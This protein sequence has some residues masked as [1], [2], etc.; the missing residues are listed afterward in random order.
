MKTIKTIMFKTTSLIYVYIMFYI[1]YAFLCVQFSNYLGKSIDIASENMD[2][3]V[4]YSFLMIFITIGMFVSFI[5]YRFVKNNYQKKVFHSV[6]TN[7]FNCIQ[8]K[9][10]CEF[11]K[12]NEKDYIGMLVNNSKIIEEQY[13]TP[14]FSVVES[15][16][17]L[18]L[19]IITLVTIDV[20]CAIFVVVIS[21]MPIIIPMIFMAKLQVNMNNYA[22]F[23][24]TFLEKTT[25]QLNGYET[26]KNYNSVNYVSNI[27]KSNNKEL[28]EKKKTAFLTMDVL[29][30]ALAVASNLMLIGILI[31]GMYMAL[32]NK[33]SVGQVFALMFISGTIVSPINDISQNLPQILGVKNILED[34]ENYC[35]KEKS[36]KENVKFNELERVD[37]KD[38][39]LTIQNINIL[40]DVNIGFEKGKKYLLVGASGSGKSTIIRGLLGY[41]NNYN[42]N[43]SYNGYNQKDIN[44]NNVYD[45]I[46]YLPQ[47]TTIFSGTLRDNL[48]MF[49]NKYTDSVLYE[50]LELVNLIDRV[51]EL[52]NGLDTVIEENANTFSGGEK[53]RL[54][55]ARALLKGKKVFVL[56]EATSALDYKNY[57]LIEEILFRIK[58]STVISV[59]HRYDSKVLKNYDMIFVV[60]DGKIVEKGSFDQLISNNGYFNSLYYTQVFE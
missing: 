38:Y 37:I 42:G 2:A 51:K 28:G 3:F 53:Q 55:I 15:V 43:I 23:N 6:K 21:F 8:S 52:N 44:I 27:F 49:N 18:L 60:N 20:G 47:N 10:F 46:A 30:N 59:S 29:M 1:T 57:L 7:L 5:I 11:S 25:E 35:K 31:F 36:N 33:I 24:A 9:D 58:D 41:Y 14:F 17:M 39:T 34:Y 16:I 54:A 19:A 4:K 45:M 32:S 26:F 40:S 12:Y 22:M 13:I 50:V 48:T 56:D